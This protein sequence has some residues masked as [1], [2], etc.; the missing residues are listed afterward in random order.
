[1]FTLVDARSDPL[2]SAPKKKTRLS[3]PAKKDGD[4]EEEE[5]EGTPEPEGHDE[6]EDEEEATG[7]DEDAEANGAEK[8]GP[9]V[10]KVQRGKAAEAEDAPAAA[11][12]K[13]D[14]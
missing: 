10:K 1:V 5:E 12:A 2:V 3:K 8:K 4:E 9:A 11:V 6:D 7:K 14:E 13:D